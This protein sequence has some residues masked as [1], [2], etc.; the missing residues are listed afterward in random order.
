MILVLENDIDILNE[1]SNGNVDIAVNSFVR[2]YQ[3]FVYA[4]SY[5]YLKDYDDADDASQEVFIKAINSLPRFK[6]Q[7]SMK[8]WIYKITINHCNNVITRN[9]FKKLFRISNADENFDLVSNYPKPD[10]IIEGAELSEKLNKLIAKLPVKQR[11]TFILRQFE[12]LTYEEISKL[13]GTSIGG[14]KANYHQALK[15]ISEG[16]KTTINGEI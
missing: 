15:K 6:F 5:R 4:T 12:E 14:L 1:Y 10:Q 2:K 8:A 11:E 9:K 3:N 13:L 16:L 7:S